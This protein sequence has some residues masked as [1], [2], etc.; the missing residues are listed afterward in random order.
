MNFSWTEDIETASTNG[1][2]LWWNPHF[3]LALKPKVRTTILKHELWH[4]AFL[5]MLR[6]G[7]RDPLIWNYAADIII[8]NMLDDEGDSFEDLKPWLDHQYDGWTTEAV[9][10]ELIKKRDQQLEQLKNFQLPA[11]WMVNPITGKSDDSD[12]VEADDPDA[13]KSIEHTI[14][15]NVVSAAHSSALG[16]GAG[17]MPGEIEVT[18]KRFLSPKLPWE[19]ILHNFF[20]ERAN[21]DYS[22]ARPNRRYPRMYLP[23]LMDDHQGLDHIAY[24]LDV[25]GSI[26]D[27]DII[28]FHS[29][30]K[31][32][33]EHFQPEKMTMLQ[34]DTR[35]TD[36]K[37][38]LQEDP[39]EESHVI[40]RG[41]TCLICVRDWIIEHEPTAVVVFSDLR[42]EPMRPLPAGM[43]VPIIWIALNNLNAR[44]PHGQLVH[45]RE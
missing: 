45:L 40:G 3:F 27:G 29:E 17:T 35:I 31:Y 42:C 21:Q 43:N 14:L 12:L 10:D 7:N 22:W 4:P 16:G 30:F 9:Y 13:Q 34:F 5:H 19:Q 11:P 6:R 44:V 25:S 24:F 18:L 2:T 38:F 36:E 37:V 8:N 39:F 33:K 15:N 28:R 32:V 20:N 23:S 1:I 41:G 26:S